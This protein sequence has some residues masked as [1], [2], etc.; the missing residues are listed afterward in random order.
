VTYA[1]APEEDAP[2]LDAA[3]A[4]LVVDDTPSKRLAIRAILEPLGLTIVE[5]DSGEKALHEVMGRTFAVILM[6]VQMPLMDGYETARLIRMR[7]ECEDTPIIFVTAHSSDEAQIAVAYASGAVDFIF[8]PIFPE[9]LRAKVA[10]FVELF[11]SARAL[12]RSL[13]DVTTLGERY[14]DGE[15]QIRSVLDHV[16]DGIVTVNRDGIIESFNRAACDL[17]GYGENEAIGQPFSLMVVPEHSRDLADHEKVTLQLF[18]EDQRGTGSTEAR[19][20]RK[21]AST[22]PME[23]DLSDVQLGT[24]QVHIACLRDCSER[25]RYTE[26]LKYKALHDDL[27]DLP[28]R[29]LFEDRAGNAIR[30]ALRAKKQLALL[31]LDLDEFKVVNDTLGHHT[32]DQ[33]LQH[34]AARLTECLRDGD[35]VARLGGDEFAILPLG[36]IDL[37]GVA[38][39]AWKIQQALAPPFVID[40]EI[41]EINAS[42]GMVLAPLHGDN[43]DD[44]VRR[45]DLAMYGVKHSGGGYALFATEQEE[46]P[47]RRLALLDNLRHCIERDELVLHYQPKIDLTTRETVGVEA[48]IRGNHPSRGLLMPGEFVPEVEGNELM[49]SISKWVIEEALTQLHAWREDGFDLTMAVNLG[50]RCLTEGSGIFEKVEEVTTALDIPPD[51]ITFEL[52]ESAL[53]DT[54]GPEMLA[55]LE[56]MNVSIDDFGTGYSSLVYLQRLPVVEIKA[57]RSFVS[58]LTSVDSD[59]V[60][61]Q[62]IVDLAH[63]LSVQVVAEGVE[64]DETMGRLLDFGSDA[65]QGY[66][67]SRPVPSADLARWLEASE[68]GLPRRLDPAPV[69]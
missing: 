21:D 46:A 9:I 54:D 69:A 31:L 34:V 15:A 11:L 66:Y 49:I 3:A 37:P 58:S 68:F 10:I 48:L 29:V 2:E 27:T 43:V 63:N 26:T 47:A 28:N 65:A 33:L 59:A 18:A 36:E 30:L 7:E 62:S 45:A 40:D 64:D 42:I 1:P 44:L 6:D 38:T 56:T 25:Q 23:I 60:I 5:A 4:I 20:C 14:R 61:V 52:T 53:I 57:D 17:L 24:R 8:A 22:F 13:S 51:K 12:E 39:V 35:T 50:A 55:R 67:F 19:G 41:I 16:A 32:G